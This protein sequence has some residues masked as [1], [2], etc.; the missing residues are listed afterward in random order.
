MVP[1]GTMVDFWTGPGQDVE[2]RTDK[3]S[4]ALQLRA[5]VQ[6]LHGASPAATLARLLLPELLRAAPQCP[7]DAMQHS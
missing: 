3:D 6:Q 7:A 1:A 4:S 2:V 5:A